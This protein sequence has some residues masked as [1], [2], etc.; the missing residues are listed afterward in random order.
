MSSLMK[1]PS[2]IILA[3]GEGSRIGTPKAILEINGRYFLERVI[4]TLIMAGVEH[5]SVV[6]GAEADR[7]ISVADLSDVEVVINYN[8]MDGQF[9]SLKVAVAELDFVDDLLVFPVDHPMVRPTT[10]LQ[11]IEAASNGD[12]AVVPIH[13]GQK[14]HPVIVRNRLIKRILNAEPDATLK[15]IIWKQPSAVKK[16]KIN[17]PGVLQNVD[18]PDDYSQIV[19]QSR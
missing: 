5:I 11:L 9:S 4:D 2:A 6:L 12:A 10:V 18:T 15:D 8:Y 1:I 16:L 17:D 3:A 14:G 7:I 19:E 13:K